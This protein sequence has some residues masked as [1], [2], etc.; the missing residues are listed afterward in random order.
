MQPYEVSNMKNYVL[1]G[2]RS[3]TRHYKIYTL[4][5]D[6]N[7]KNNHRF[8]STQIG[9]GINNNKQFEMVR[10]RGTKSH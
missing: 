9:G 2:P 8:K 3:S 7:V 10:F 5:K 1:I 6:E 4:E